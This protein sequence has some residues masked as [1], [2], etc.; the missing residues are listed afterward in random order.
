MT[1]RRRLPNRR[2]SESFEFE[3]GGLK[4]TA[5]VSWYPDG[6]IG[7]LF[8]SCH[9][10]MSAADTNARDAAIAFSIAIQHGVDV[11]LI[12]DALCRNRDGSASGPLG[13]ALDYITKHELT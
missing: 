1:D 4:Y 2:R 6:T 13:A 8:I 12:R 7:E 5:T 3:N 10:A 11:G 9:K